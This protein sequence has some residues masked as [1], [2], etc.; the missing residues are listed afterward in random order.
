MVADEL[1][2]LSL[3]EGQP[4]DGKWELGYAIKLDFPVYATTKRV[5]LWTWPREQGI[6]RP[7][8]QLDYLFHTYILTIV[9][10]HTITL[11]PLTPRNLPYLFIRIPR[12]LTDVDGLK[13]RL[14]WHSSRIVQPTTDR[15]VIYD[16]KHPHPTSPSPT[17]EFSAL[18]HPL[19]S[20]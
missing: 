12:G 20:H 2:S 7:E 18:L 17:T 15:C 8:I 1:G 5:C 3:I 13:L 6:Y 4:K 10:D 9:S 16:R 19:Q 14:P 11:D